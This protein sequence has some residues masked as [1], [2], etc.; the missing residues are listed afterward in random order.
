M[1]QL[2]EDNK[3]LARRMI[4]ALSDADVD[5]IKETYAEDFL[6]WVAGSLPFSGTGDKASAV[7]GMPAVLSLF[8]SGLRFSIVAMTA[9]A[10][11]VAIEATSTGTTAKDRQY[12]QQY[13][14][15][16]RVRDGKIVEWKEYMDTEH[17]RQVLVGAEQP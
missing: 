2:E 12:E 11:R 14:F 6:I 5:F 1:G 4:E 17:A 10:D 16:M 3:E 8:P 9:E 13:H 7:A 15:L